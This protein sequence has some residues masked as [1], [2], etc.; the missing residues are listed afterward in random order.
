MQNDEHGRRKKAA[1]RCHFLCGKKVR[2]II[3]KRISKFEK[4]VKHFI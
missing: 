2:T 4:S 1:F 3:V